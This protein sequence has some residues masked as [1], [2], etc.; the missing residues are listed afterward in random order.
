MLKRKAVRKMLVTTMSIFIIMVL[1]FIPTTSNERVLNTNLELEYI[2]GIG[3]NHIY[4]TN[5]NNYLVRSKILLDEKTTEAKLKMLLSN[6]TIQETTKFPTGLHATIPLGTTI[7]SIQIEEN[8]VLLNFS[9]EILRVQ[10]DKEKRMIESIVYSVL[11]L[12]EL[13]TLEIQ[14][15]GKNLEAYPNSKEKLPII[16]DRNYGINQVFDL[17]SLQGS[18]KVV[19]YY[20]EQIQNENYYVPVTRYLTDD[21]EKIQIIVDCLTSSYIY[22]PNLMSLAREDVSLMDYE[23]N[24]D[25]FI[26]N[27][28]DALLQEDKIKEEVLYTIAMSVFANYDVN[29]VSFQINGVEKAYLQEKD[30][31]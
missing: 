22:E 6:L 17:N 15:E 29:T 31:P 1:Y 26:L 4:L 12:K 7:K 9:K 14:V 27:F 28:N 18:S 16:Y 24:E 13:T 20:L 3:N 10:E 8:H 2:T 21:R 23:I 5:D 11:D 25:L 30:I 19:V